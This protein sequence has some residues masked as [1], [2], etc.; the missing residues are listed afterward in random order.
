MDFVG[1]ESNKSQ[2]EDQTLLSKCMH[3]FSV[4]EAFLHEEMSPVTKPS[5]KQKTSMW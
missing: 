1:S 5:K 4:N 3:D 2:E